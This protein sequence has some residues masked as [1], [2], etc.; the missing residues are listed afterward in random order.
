MRTARFSGRL[1]GGVWS[2]GC[3]FRGCLSRGFWLGPG[4]VCVQGVYTPRTQT[5]TLLHAG[6]H[7]PANC[8]LGYIPLRIAC[9]DTSPP[10][11]WTKWLTDGCKKLL[12]AASFAGCNNINLNTQ[13]LCK[14]ISHTSRFHMRVD[15]WTRTLR[16]LLSLASESWWRFQGSWMAWRNLSHVLVGR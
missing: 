10:P 11:L 7:T 6:I 13:Y 8:L 5:Q 3:L 16:V 14:Q 1:G 4:C 9:W 15:T 2:L 12:H